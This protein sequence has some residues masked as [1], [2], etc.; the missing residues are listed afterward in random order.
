MEMAAEYACGILCP[1]QAQHLLPTHDLALIGLSRDLE[2]ACTF[3][4]EAS[5]VGCTWRRKALL[6]QFMSGYDPNLETI[7]KWSRPAFVVLLSHA[8]IL[9]ILCSRAATI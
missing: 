2:S 3:D 5:G 6:M 8:R 9:R 4:E 7:A 1:E